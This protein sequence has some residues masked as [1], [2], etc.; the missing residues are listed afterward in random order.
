MKQRYKAGECENVSDN[1]DLVVLTVYNK[2]IN[3]HSHEFHTVS[4]VEESHIINLNNHSLMGST[5][6]YLTGCRLVEDL[7]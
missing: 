2:N 3:R 1:G 6:N 7:V 4:S 5:D